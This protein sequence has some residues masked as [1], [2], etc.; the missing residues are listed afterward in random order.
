MVIWNWFNLPAL[1]S[2]GCGSE[3]RH[4]IQ[5][6]VS[7]LLKGPIKDCEWLWALS[8]WR[9]LQSTVSSYISISDV[10]ISVLCECEAFKSVKIIFMHFKNEKSVRALQR[11]VSFD[12]TPSN[13]DHSSYSPYYEVETGIIFI[14]IWT[15]GV[16]LCQN[17]YWG[18]LRALLSLHVLFHGPE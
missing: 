1:G 4:N 15:K 14:F 11:A 12:S 9:K 13:S 3:D 10:S 2:S 8:V 7:L 5:H 6:I 18:P 17:I 16:P